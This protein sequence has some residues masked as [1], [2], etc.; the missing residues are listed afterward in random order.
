MVT[1]V[2]A[3]LAGPISS[4]QRWTIVGAICGACFVLTIAAGFAFRGW[5]DRPPRHPAD[6]KVAVTSDPSAGEIRPGRDDV[7]SHLKL[8]AGTV[9]AEKEWS[10]LKDIWTRES[11]DELPIVLARFRA[12]GL[13][14]APVLVPVLR[15]SQDDGERLL[16]LAALARA[17]PETS[18]EDLG[19]MVLA[20]ALGEALADPGRALATSVLLEGHPRPEKTLVLVALATPNLPWGIDLLARYLDQGATSEETDLLLLAVRS[21]TSAG[22]P[23]ATRLLVSLLARPFSSQVKEEVVAQLAEHPGEGL[24]GEIERMLTSAQ[25]ME[26]KVLLGGLLTQMAMREGSTVRLTDGMKNSLRPVL[27]ATLTEPRVSDALRAQAIH[28]LGGLG[29]EQSLQ[30]L[31]DAMKTLVTPDL[32]QIASEELGRHAERAQGYMLVDGFK[33]EEYKVN[34]IYRLSAAIDIAERTRA[35]DLRMQAIEKGAPY[36]RRILLE[37]THGSIKLEAMNT[38]VRMGPGTANQVLWDVAAN[39]N[40]KPLVRMHALS[41]LQETGGPSEAEALAQLEQRETNQQL[42]DRMHETREKLLSRGR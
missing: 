20:Q 38:L 35:N 13:D 8:P 11:L 2:E 26:D 25:S 23:E 10:A 33:G 37:T 3:S 19:A 15:N 28:A 5:R 40:E 36:L 29:D 22:G 41:H 34:E 42:K 9:Q 27:A 24:A 32:V 12:I 16:A 30:A 31:V 18:P 7:P 14:A 4:R 17:L 6:P 21:A 39:P 1:S